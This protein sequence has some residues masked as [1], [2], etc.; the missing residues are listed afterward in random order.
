[1][2]PATFYNF[3]HEQ[4]LPFLKSGE[5]Q[6][7]GGIL[8]KYVESS[9]MEPDAQKRYIREYL[10][11][12]GDI[13][14]Y[15]D[16]I[17][18]I[19][20]SHLET[21]SDAF[22]SELRKTLKPTIL[23]SASV[24]SYWNSNTT[25]KMKVKTNTDYGK[26]I[27]V[28]VDIV[29]HN[30]KCPIKFDFDVNSLILSKLFDGSIEFR[31]RAYH[32]IDPI[33][34]NVRSRTCQIVPGE[35]HMKRI[36]KIINSG[37]TINMKNYDEVC[38]AVYV[39]DNFDNV[40]NMGSFQLMNFILRPQ[41]LDFLQNHKL[42]KDRSSLCK[43][44]KIYW[45]RWLVTMIVWSLKVGMFEKFRPYVKHFSDFSCADSA[46][47]LFERIADDHF[48]VYKWVMNEVG[49]GHRKFYSLNLRHITTNID[50]L[51]Y[52]YNRVGHFDKEMLEKAGYS[53]F[54]TFEFVMSK[55]GKK[56]LKKVN[57]KHMSGVSMLGDYRTMKWIKDNK[58]IDPELDDAFWQ[59]YRNE[60]RFELYDFVSTE[61]YSDQF[62]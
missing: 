28:K 30:Y 52:M 11:N 6:L 60:F 34:N 46:T 51:E 4:F 2:N 58:G 32:E 37:Y 29:E 47:L 44:Y 49:Y 20:R 41:L 1:M 36:V 21:N 8:R 9:D 38:C 18:I 57:W 40:E 56:Q 62:M 24:D 53:S 26:D 42:A 55:M 13:D 33:L 3:I 25:L 48:E 61:M 23:V 14:V 59:N 16:R 17:D 19:R 50:A 15:T 39:N 27:V 45:P 54:E 12:N 35:I 5:Y 7:F 31:S 43:K 22:K 10:Q